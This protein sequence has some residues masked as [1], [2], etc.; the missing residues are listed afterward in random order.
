MAA[1]DG[2]VNYMSTAEDC[3][4]GDEH[5]REAAQTSSFDFEMMGYDS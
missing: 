3:T 5:E 2:P 4:V 1:Y